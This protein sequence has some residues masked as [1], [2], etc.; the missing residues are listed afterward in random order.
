MADTLHD[1]GYRRLRATGLKGKH[2]EALV[3]EW[4]RQ[5]LSIGTIKNRMTHL[6]WWAK[7]IG[8]GQSRAPGTTR[9]TGSG[10]RRHVTNEDRSRDLPPEKLA[11][12]DDEHVRMALRLEEGVRPAPRGGDQVL[13]VVRGPGSEDRAEGVYHEGWTVARDSGC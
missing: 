11:R 1:L 2:V 9:A 3:R 4:K 8:Q 13:A 10:N 12:V 5:R 7:R 6:R